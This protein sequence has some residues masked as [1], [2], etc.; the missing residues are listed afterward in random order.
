MRALLA[1]LTLFILISC[2]NSKDSSSNEVKNTNTNS[3]VLDTILN[4]H[5]TV[6][7]LENEKLTQGI[8]NEIRFEIEEIDAKNIVIYTSTSEATVKIGKQF[9]YFEVTPVLTVKQVTIT[10]NHLENGKMIKLGQIELKTT[11]NTCSKIIA[12]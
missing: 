4:K 9:G 1:I 3:F 11:H 2:A 6:L 7:T 12:V 10:V 5:R 8:K